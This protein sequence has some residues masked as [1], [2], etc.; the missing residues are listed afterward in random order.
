MSDASAEVMAAFELERL[1]HKAAA[2]RFE[3]TPSG[4]VCANPDLPMVWD[5][6]R[7]QVEPDGEPPDLAGI[8]E[9]AARPGAWFPE[10]RHRE[11]YIAESNQGREVAWSL[12]KAGWKLS[13]HAMLVCREA[14]R[15]VPRAAQRIEGAAM[16]RLKGR[17]GVEQGLAPGSIAQFDRYDELRARA[18]ARLTY[19]GFEG[20]LPLAIADM[21][22]RG[23]IA[24]IED[25]ATLRRGRRRGLASAA[26]IGAA[27]AALRLSARAVYLFA[28]PDLA[29]TFYEPIGFE[30]IGGAFECQLPPS[31]G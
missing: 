26:V 17:L 22:L 29:K 7:V 28:D 30:R 9:L 10:L 31:S 21:Y 19:A 24:V 27:A 11:V 4:F 6:S 20:K 13:E 12:A 25:V 2:S 18:G 23:D 15:S 5:A 3:R 16:R 8:L 1:M 14:P